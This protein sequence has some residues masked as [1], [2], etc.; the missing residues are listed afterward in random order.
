MKAK[1]AELEQALVGQIKPHH[2]F[3]LSEQLRLIDTL[4]EAMGRVSQEIEARISAPQA[5]PQEETA[6]VEACQ[7]QDSGPADQQEA[8]EEKPPLT[9]AQAIVLLCTIPGISRRAAEVILAE[10]GLDLSRFPSA[11][12]LA[13]WAGMC[14]GHHQS[15]GKR[16]SGRTRKGSPWLRKL[17]VEA[18]HAAAHTKKTYLASQYR[19]LAA[20]GGPKKAMVAVGHS[21][22]VIIYHVL[23]DQKPYHELGGNSFDERDRQ[24]LEKRLVRRLEKLGY[25]V[26]LQSPA[27]AA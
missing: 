19:R 17:L 18:A 16:L 1:R 4:E 5:A 8:Q 25:Q 2:H 3:M 10:I 13:S 14:P 6:S 23:R 26:S 11:R 12:H 20:R 7:P 21:I 24:A 27:P 22:L 15:A 9:W